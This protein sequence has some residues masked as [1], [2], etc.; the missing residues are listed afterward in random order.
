[1]ADPYFPTLLGTPTA[2]SYGYQ[3]QNTEIVSTP[4]ES[5]FVRKRQRSKNIPSNFMFN[6]IF[7]EIQLGMFEYFNQ[8]ILESLTLRFNI[9]LATGQGII[10]Y[11]A[12]YAEA[13]KV[14]KIG[15]IFQ[16]SCNVEAHARP[17]SDFLPQF[18][19]HDLP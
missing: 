15:V 14:K 5:G 13:P 3:D 8:Y 19:A 6:F 12:K 18:L 4:M 1:M 2:D 11:N 16:V 9:M 17:L 7:D 10:Y